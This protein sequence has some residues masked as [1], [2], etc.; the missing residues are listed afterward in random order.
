MT[1]RRKTEYPPELADEIRKLL[2][3]Y[4]RKQIR[5]ALIINRTAKPVADEAERIWLAVET[6]KAALQAKGRSGHVLSTKRICERLVKAKLRFQVYT[7]ENRR[8]GER[9]VRRITNASYLRRLYNKA[10]A[11]TKPPH[12]DPKGLRKLL[13]QRLAKASGR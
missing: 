12:N 6:E 5:A 11:L 9:R 10:N 7:S 1:G 4:S 2:E 3:L 8:S 13:K